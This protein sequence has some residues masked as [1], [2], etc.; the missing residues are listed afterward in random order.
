[1]YEKAHFEITRELKTTHE[2]PTSAY[3]PMTD[4]LNELGIDPRKYE[5]Q[6]PYLDKPGYLSISKEP[7]EDIPTCHRIERSLVDI[8]TYPF[9]KN[10]GI[11]FP[12]EL[13]HE[14]DLV[15][16]LESR[17]IEPDGRVDLFRRDLENAL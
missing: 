4:A 6:Y 7:M 11:V 9:V 8:L 5:F 15:L 1:M 2:S 17:L 12:L 16:V 14:D 3:M 13:V 10:V